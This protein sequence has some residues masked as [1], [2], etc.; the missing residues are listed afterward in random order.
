M[1]TVY[2]GFFVFFC[3]HLI[4]AIEDFYFHGFKIL[5]FLTYTNSQISRPYYFHGQN[6][7]CKNREK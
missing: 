7:N 4:F 2:P 6:A 5:V 3:G 1:N